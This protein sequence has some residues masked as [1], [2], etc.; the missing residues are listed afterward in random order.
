MLLA[1]GFFPC[2]GPSAQIAARP[3]RLSQVL[4]LYGTR[5]SLGQLQRRLRF[6][7]PD[8]NIAFTPR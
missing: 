8:F 3:F 5:E 7:A 4:P 6:V 1:C 2:R